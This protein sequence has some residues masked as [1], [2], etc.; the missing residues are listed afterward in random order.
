MEDHFSGNGKGIILYSSG[1][2]NGKPFSYFTIY[3]D[4]QY[5]VIDDGQLRWD[6]TQCITEEELRIFWNTD[7]ICY[8]AGITPSRHHMA[9][10]AMQKRKSKVQRPNYYQSTACI[11]HEQ[12]KVQYSEIRNEWTTQTSVN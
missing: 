4:E 11:K 1:K 10:V 6:G 7:G 5:K 3:L 8:L 9:D 2:S 12:G